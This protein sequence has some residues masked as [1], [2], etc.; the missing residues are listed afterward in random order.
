MRNAYDPRGRLET[1]TQTGAN[2]IGSREWRYSYDAQ[3]NLAQIVDPLNRINRFGYDAVGRVTKQTLPD[4]REVATSGA[5][6]VGLIIGQMDIS[7]QG[8]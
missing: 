4:G 7:S 6:R 2:G 3:G 8:S 1:M 5:I